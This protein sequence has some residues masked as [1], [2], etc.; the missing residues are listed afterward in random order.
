VII[1]TAWHNLSPIAI[2]LASLKKQEDMPLV[3]FYTRPDYRRQ[4]LSLTLGELVS[5][6]LDKLYG[7]GNYTV[8]ADKGEGWGTGYTLCKKLGHSVQVFF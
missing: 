6:E 4:G 8:I 7:A 2:C 5:R 1:A 3:G